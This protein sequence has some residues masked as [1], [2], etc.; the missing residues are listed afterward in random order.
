MKLYR[1]IGATLR[2]KRFWIWQLGGVIIYGIPAAIRFVTG[3]VQLPV[4]SLLE[5]PILDHYVPANLVEKILINAFFPGGAGGIAGEVFAGNYNGDAV[6]GKAK[7]L[8]RLGGALL[9]TAAW[10]VFQFWGYSLEIF[11]PWS[12]GG[13][14]GNIFEY[15]TVFPL[16]FILA[17]FS[18]FTPDIVYFMK[19]TVDKACR[20]LK[21]K[22]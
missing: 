4:L 14:W 21:E 1:T 20:K 10:S 16:N 9:Q 13:G 7:Y 2:S 17:A 22:F 6:K 12:I 18:I 3:N 19:S 5:T 11:G 15:W 8:S